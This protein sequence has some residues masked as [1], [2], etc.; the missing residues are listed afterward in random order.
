[1]IR[2]SHLIFFL[3]LIWGTSD[4]FGKKPD[5]IRIGICT[6]VHLNLM[7]DS[8]LR[9]STFI[10]AM[11]KAKPDFIIEMGDFVTPDKKFASYFDTWNLF[12]GDKYHVIGN[13][14]TDGGFSKNQVLESRRMNHPYYSFDKNG[15]HFIVL[16]GNDK[17]SPDTKPYY[18]LI[19]PEQMAWLKSN[20]AET[21]HPV[22]LFSH[23]GLFA[24]DG[25]DG[26][27]VENYREVQE[28]L[29]S[30]NLHHPEKR[31]IAC[32]NGHTHF[33]YA[34]NI[35]GIW[36]I[37][38]T[39]MSYHWLGEKYAQIRY[40]DEIDKKFPWIKM[41]APFKDPLFTVVEISKKRTIRVAGK[42]SVWVGPSP[43][44]LGYPDKFKK[45][46]RPEIT[47]RK[48]KFEL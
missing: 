17:K 22:V 7:H 10:G 35:K 20:L 37:T 6:D 28:I 42:K 38:I 44:E 1:M 39:S 3:G 9:L 46:M 15:F 36:Y 25:E 48:L 19:G 21:I 26:G 40:S 43:W 33:D 30:H 11:N 23:Q 34:Q 41:T 4:S 5:Q 27:S 29:D 13:H 47:G 16:D 18:R 14:E 8:E 24:L 12:Q 31:V 2:L 32:F 45:Y